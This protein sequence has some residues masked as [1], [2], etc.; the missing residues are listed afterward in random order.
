MPKVGD[1]TARGFLSSWQKHA[2]PIFKFKSKS[3]IHK[4]V[5]TKAFLAQYKNIRRDW[6]DLVSIFMHFPQPGQGLSPKLGQVHLCF[7]YRFFNAPFDL[8]Q[9]HNLMYNWKILEADI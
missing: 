2:H 5:E 7:L 3:F 9:A 8:S 6:Q 4:T 1:F